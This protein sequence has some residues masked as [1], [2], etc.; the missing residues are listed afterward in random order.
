MD[1][2]KG[3]AIILMVMPAWLQFCYIISLPL[4]PWYCC[5][6]AVCM[7]TSQL[8]LIL[9]LQ[10]WCCISSYVTNSTIQLMLALYCSC[11]YDMIPTPMSLQHS[12]CYDATVTM[13]ILLYLLWCHRW[14]CY[15]CVITTSDDSMIMP[16]ILL[17]YLVHFCCHRSEYTT[18]VVIL[19]G[20]WYDV[21]QES[22]RWMINL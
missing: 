5:H 7:I 2:K 3:V 21:Q 8:L 11:L 12:L 10:L 22:E 1:T 4:L 19:E 16:L 9:L 17:W 6:D 14:F 20:V 18:P 13:L 15:Y